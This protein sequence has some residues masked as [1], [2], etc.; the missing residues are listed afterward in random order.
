VVAQPD[1]QKG[2][3]KHKGSGG[4]LWPGDSPHADSDDDDD[5]GNPNAKPYVSPY[6]YKPERQR[7]E[8]ACAFEL[9][10]RHDHGGVGDG[11]ENSGYRG[12]GV[13]EDDEAM[14][15]IFGPPTAAGGGGGSGGGGG[16]V[17]FPSPSI[18]R[19]AAERAKASRA[20]F[21][22][23]Q[24]PPPPAPHPARV[25]PPPPTAGSAAGG[26]G[27][28]KG[29]KKKSTLV[30]LVHHEVNVAGIYGGFNQVLLLNAQRLEEIER[31]S[32]VKLAARSRGHAAF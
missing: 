7:K 19:A 29:V 17:S 15:A 3:S 28:G 26:G 14:V 20:F 24:P 9:L 12:N 22:R 8:Q 32:L 16:N 27:V 10:D 11:G 30:T 18:A 5:D 1:D 13:E 6:A 21:S 23:S 31:K 4:Q 2:A 25:L